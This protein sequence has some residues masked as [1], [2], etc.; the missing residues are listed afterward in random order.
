M[1]FLFKDDT[2]SYNLGYTAGKAVNIPKISLQIK[3]QG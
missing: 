2:I 1:T 3:S